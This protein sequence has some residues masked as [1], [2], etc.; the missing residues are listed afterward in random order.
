MWEKQRSRTEEKVL[1]LCNANG[2]PLQLKGQFQLNE[3]GWRAVFP[4]SPSFWSD[5]CRSWKLCLVV[6]LGPP[7]VE[8]DLF[9]QGEQLHISALLRISIYLCAD[10]ESLR[11]PVLPSLQ[12]HRSLCC[13]VSAQQSLFESPSLPR[14]SKFESIEIWIII[15]IVKCHES[16][17]SARNL[18]ECDMTIKFPWSV[19]SRHFASLVSAGIWD[20]LLTDHS[21]L[22]NSFWSLFWNVL[23]LS[24][25]Y[26]DTKSSTFLWDQYYSTL[27]H[28][29]WRMSRPN[30]NI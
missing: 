12:V 1:W 14:Q 27:T 17:V 5:V 29:I 22:R 6:K 4:G 13:H 3:E 21:M 24:T 20:F 26:A 28:G 8:Q 18:P 19:S 10:M 16:P 23:Y 25:N 11:V 2:W 9:L 30:N 15:I 7:L